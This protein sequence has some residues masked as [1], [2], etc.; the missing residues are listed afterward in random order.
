[1]VVD[2]YEVQTRKDTL[3]AQNPLKD[4]FGVFRGQGGRRGGGGSR[5]ATGGRKGIEQ[6]QTLIDFRPS[7]HLSSGAT[8]L[9]IH[10]H[11]QGMDVQVG[12]S[13]G[14]VLS[15]GKNTIQGRV[16]RRHIR[17]RHIIHIDLYRSFVHSL[18]G[19]NLRESC[20]FQVLYEET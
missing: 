14:A 3:F 2:V 1:M 16:H 4:A 9:Q 12:N 20:L 17:N 13:V 15:L 19:G 18:S 7:L 11:S 5:T 8:Q 10:H 6:H